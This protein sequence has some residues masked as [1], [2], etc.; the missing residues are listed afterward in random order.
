MVSYEAFPA[1]KDLESLLRGWSSSSKTG[2]GSKMAR[3]AMFRKQ[4]VPPFLRTVFLL[5][6]NAFA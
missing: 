1:I 5:E 6:S 2:F 4:K 3:L